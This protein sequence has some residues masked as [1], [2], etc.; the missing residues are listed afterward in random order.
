RT[1]DKAVTAKISA[2]SAS[3]QTG[4]LGA[5]VQ[6][7]GKGRLVVEE[8]QPE[9]P[10]DKAG[11]KKGDVVTRVG[12]HPVRTPDAFREWVQTHGPGNAVK[13]GLLREDKSVEVTAT[14]IATSR[15]MKYGGQRV[16]FG[17]QL[18]E[19]KEGEGA[20][21]DQ[22]TANAPAAQAGLKSGARIVKFD[23][24]NVASAERVRTAV[25]DKAPGDSVTLTVMREGKEVELKVTLTADRFGR[26]EGGPI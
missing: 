2:G 21:V 20:P 22:V 14:L 4:Y 19:G 10:A 11:V 12:D 15:P 9:S 17:A 16:Y 6:R 25:A 24:R 7:D 13:I 23:G 26:G 5:A 1:V 18:G 8:V 3:G